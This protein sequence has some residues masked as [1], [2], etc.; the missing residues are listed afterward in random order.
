MGTELPLLPSTRASLGWLCCPDTRASQ[1]LP[2]GQPAASPPA[3]LH[4]AHAPVGS[5]PPGLSGGGCSPCPPLLPG[6]L[7]QLP[8]L[9]MIFS[10]LDTHSILHLTYSL[11]AELLVFQHCLPSL[12]HML[13]EPRK[14]VCVSLHLLR[15]EPCLAERRCPA[16][17]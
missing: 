16:S 8:G 3:L 17:V 4:G 10:C 13:L 1:N 12:K 11:E 5:S 7:P 2:P 9:D 6:S 15:L 14:N